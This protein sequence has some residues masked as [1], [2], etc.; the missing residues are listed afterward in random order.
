MNRKTEA[1]KMSQKII[2]KMTEDEKTKLQL[3]AGH[4]G[5]TVS[6]YARHMISNPSSMADKCFARKVKP[7]IYEMQT[8]QNMIAAGIDVEVQ[9]EKLRELVERLCAL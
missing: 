1:K 9:E 4:A 6:D 7:I 5:M 2:V 8:Y 3:K